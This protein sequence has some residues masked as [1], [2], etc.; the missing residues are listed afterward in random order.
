M[1][2]TKTPVIQKEVLRDKIFELVKGWILDG[3]LEPGERI[4]ESVLA[5]QINVSRAPLREALWLLAHE[6]LVE[7]RPHQGAF[8]TELSLQDLAEIFELREV[9]ETYAAKRIRAT[10]TPAKK[11]SLELALQ[12]L[13]EAGRA[14]DVNSFSAADFR[15]HKALWELAGNRHL[16]DLLSEVAAR[17]FYKLIR[18]LPPGAPFP[19]E[20][21]VAEHRTLVRATLEGTNE[22]IEAGF[23]RSF[24]VFRAYVLERFGEQQAASGED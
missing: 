9:L 24:A 23:R 6:G 15:F 4:V 17:F 18:D 20:E 1:K 7:L 14:R 12:D 16:Q 5:R 11:Q 21:M 2:T 19:F 22:Q 3:T 8:V 13:E 10:L